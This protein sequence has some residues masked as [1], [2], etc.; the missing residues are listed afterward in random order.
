MLAVTRAKFVNIFIK[1]VNDTLEKISEY[2][3]LFIVRQLAS[4]RNDN[5][6]K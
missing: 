6:Q 5:Y 2:Q 4:F 3:L 1:C